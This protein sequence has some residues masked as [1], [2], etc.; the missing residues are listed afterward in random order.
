MLRYYPPIQYVSHTTRSHAQIR[1]APQTSDLFIHSLSFTPRSYAGAVS[2]QVNLCWVLHNRVS[3]YII[4]GCLTSLCQ[5]SEGSIKCVPTEQHL[6]VCIPYMSYSIG[7]RALEMCVISCACLLVRSFDAKL[8]LWEIL[9]MFNRE[10]YIM[11]D[12]GQSQERGGRRGEEKIRVA[13]L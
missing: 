1:L 4:A 12:C 8:I 11:N 6:W 13:V 2:R 5:L 7:A 9:I 10:A 3:F